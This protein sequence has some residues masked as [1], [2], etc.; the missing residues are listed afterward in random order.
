MQRRIGC[1]IWLVIA[2][3]AVIM[4]LA[5]QYIRFRLD[6]R[7]LPEG[8]T[9]AGLSVAGRTPEEALN[10]MDVAFSTPIEI[11][12]QGE[13]IL[14]PPDSVELRYDPEITAHNLAAAMQARNF[15]AYVLHSPTAPLEI[16]V[17]VTYSIERLDEFLV[18]IANQYDRP[19]QPAIPLPESLTFTPPQPGYTLD[20]AASRTRLIEALVSAGDTD[21]VVELVVRVDPPP[22][23]QSDLLD[24][25]LHTWLESH[26]DII[27]G[28]FIKDLQTGD[29]VTINADVAFSGL[30]LLKIPILVETYRR[31]DGPP[32]EE[33]ATQIGDMMGTA[34]S[35]AQANRLLSDLLGGRDA[36]RGAE[37]LTTS[38]HY[39]GL[40][41][42]FMAAP[43]DAVDVVIS[44][45]II[46]L[47]NARLDIDTHP[48]P[49]MQTTPLEIG[50]LLE[51]VY[52]CTQGGGALLAAY[53]NDFTPDECHQIIAWMERNQTDNWTEAG[54]PAGTRLAHR[55][56]FSDGTYADAALVFTSS[57][58]GESGTGSQDFVIV[59]YLFDPQGQGREVMAPLI[60]NVCQAAYNYFTIRSL[61]NQP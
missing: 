23:A 56:G 9:M 4:L 2:M 34:S 44:P 50:L 40:I 20:I 18:R 36:Y 48:S 14:L 37:H 47:A 57:E 15:I 13:R 58:D 60:A 46:T 3:L 41:N 22:P 32:T 8:T 52:Q 21:T 10:A 51:M 27:P 38:M 17:A 26:T 11:S 33:Q 59:V 12:Y 25:L 45:T 53:P 61:E 29:E 55:H 1:L 28:I 7:V 30:D 43:Y 49:D 31:L 54:V 6:S 39:L 5:W 19:V 24:Q 35:N 42:T 16:P